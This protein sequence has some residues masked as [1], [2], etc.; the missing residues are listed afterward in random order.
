MFRSIKPYNTTL[1]RINSFQ[2]LCCAVPHRRTHQIGQDVVVVLQ[3]SPLCSDLRGGEVRVN[4][5]L[6]TFL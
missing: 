4:D 6:I 2:L 3:V 1:V 5:V